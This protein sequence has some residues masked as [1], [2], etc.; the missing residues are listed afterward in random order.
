[1]VKNVNAIWT[2]DTSNNTTTQKLMKLRKIFDHGHDKYITTYD[3]KKITA[4][5]FAETLKQANLASKN[6]ITDFVKKTD[7]DDQLQI[8]IKRY[9]K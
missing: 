4:E 5:N 3:F 2:V 8:L 6:D 1:M 9:F 7:F